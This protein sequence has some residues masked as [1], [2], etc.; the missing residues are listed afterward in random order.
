MPKAKTNPSAVPAADQEIAVQENPAPVVKQASSTPSIS[1]KVCPPGV[2]A[3]QPS[4]VVERR[5]MVQIPHTDTFDDILAPEYWAH[6][7]A[8]VSPRALLTCIDE[9]LRWEAE[10]RVLEAGQ[11]WLKVAVI[12]HTPYQMTAR[13]N[14]ELEKLRSLF[15]IEHNGQNGWRILNPSGQ[16][17]VAGLASE[18]N[19]KTFLETHIAAMS[20]RASAA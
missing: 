1:V 8:K 19:A 11:T 2:K 3:F 9:H 7:A 17:L 18:A 4:D 16:P 13:G 20:L 14:S 6:H 12:R 10:L 5:F 15:K